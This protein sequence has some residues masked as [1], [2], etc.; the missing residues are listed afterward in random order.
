MR[1]VVQL[2][3]AERQ[4]HIKALLL[5]HHSRKRKYLQADRLRCNSE[6]GCAHQAHSRIKYKEAW[7]DCLL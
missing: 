2:S 3:H 1:R 4:T 6:A 5:L 7:Q